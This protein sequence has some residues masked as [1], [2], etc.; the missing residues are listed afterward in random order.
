MINHR[1]E[2]SDCMSRY[3]DRR[4]HAIAAPYATRSFISMSL[5]LSLSAMTFSLWS[6]ACLG[7]MPS[8]G[9]GSCFQ[10]SL[11]NGMLRLLIDLLMV[12]VFDK[13]HMC[14]YYNSDTY[15]WLCMKQKH[16][17]KGMLLQRAEQ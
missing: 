2:Q 4:R 10:L 15:C 5:S 14:R 17:M 11:L 6:S 8:R 1:V 13:Q 3:I 16:T 9:S 7:V 12:Q